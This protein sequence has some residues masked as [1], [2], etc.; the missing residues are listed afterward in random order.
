MLEE[1]GGAPMSTVS[2][3]TTGRSS[4]VGA[5]PGITTTASVVKTSAGAWMTPI[6][7]G[8]SE[9]RS[10]SDREKPYATNPAATTTPAVTAIIVVRDRRFASMG[11]TTTTTLLR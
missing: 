1:I 11:S 7:G 5:D 6:V 10:S 4:V 9:S 2:S 8:V 3:G